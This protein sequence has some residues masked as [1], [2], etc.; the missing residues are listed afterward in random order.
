MIVMEYVAKFIKLAHFPDDYVAT[1]MAKVWKFENGLKLSIR[2]KIVG[3][4]IQDLD[5]MVKTAMAI[6]REI[7]DAR[8]I[9]DV[10]T[11]GKRKESQFFSS[12][13]KKPKPSSSRGFQSRGHQGQGQAKAPSQAGQTIFYFSHQPSHMRRDYPQRQGS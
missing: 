3:L 4:L 5:S 1:D 9:R 7:E 2:G 11:S 13:G 10:D 8:S 6:K 12:S